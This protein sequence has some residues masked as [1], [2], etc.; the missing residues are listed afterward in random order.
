MNKMDYQQVKDRVE[1]EDKALKKIVHVIRRVSFDI[2]E[3]SHAVPGGHKIPG[4]K[5]GGYLGVQKLFRQRRKLHC[6]FDVLN[7]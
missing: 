1:R 4:V 5:S 7:G 3:R 6:V 2:Q